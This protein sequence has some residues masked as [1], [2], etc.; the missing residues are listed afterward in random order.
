M[1]FI[2]YLRMFLLVLGYFCFSQYATATENI[3]HE[4]LIEN[5]RETEKL[6]LDNGLQIYLI[7]DPYAENS[8]AAL[9][10]NAG[11]WQNPPEHLGLAHF[12]EHTLFL[13]TKKYPKESGFRDFIS[14][15]GGIYNAFTEGLFTTYLFEIQ[16][17]V[18]KESLIQFATFFEEPLFNPSGIQREKHAV[19][20]EHAGNIEKETHRREAVIKMVSNPEHPGNRFS[21]GNLETLK[22]A[23]P[24]VL[25]RWYENHYSANLMTLT[26]YSPLAM[27]ELKNLIIPVF[28]SIPN[29][30]LSPPDFAQPLFSP[31]PGAI[32]YIQ[33]LDETQTLDLV[34]EIPQDISFSIEEQPDRII[35]HLLGHEST[36]SLLSLLKKEGLANGLASG[37]YSLDQKRKV[38]VIQIDLTKKGVHQAYRVIERVFQAITTLKTQLIPRYIFDHISMT[39][40]L[41][42]LYP[43]Y[44][45]PFEEVMDIATHL[46]AYHLK[47][48]PETALVPRVYNPEAYR[49]FLQIFTPEHA[50]INI[51]ASSALTGIKHQN[52]EPWYGVEYSVQEVPRK[53]FE[54]WK[55]CQ[56]LSNLLIPKKNPWQITKLS[57]EKD[58][59]SSSFPRPQLISQDDRGTLYHSSETLYPCPEV[60]LKLQIHSPLINPSDPR[61]IALSEL[62][63]RMFLDHINEDIYEAKMAGLELNLTQSEGA[64][65][66]KVYGYHEK[67]GLLAK[68]IIEKFNT[69]QPSLEEFHKA[70]EAQSRIYKNFTNAGPLKHGFD[71]LRQILYSFYAPEKAK[72]QALTQVDFSSLR[73]FHRQLLTKTYV[74]GLAYGN[75]SSKESLEIWESIQTTLSKHPLALDERKVQNVIRLPEEPFYIEMK[76]KNRGNAVILAIEN[77]D[78]NYTDLVVSRILSQTLG[79]AFFSE[80]RTQQKTGYYVSQTSQNIY[81]HLFSFFIIES[82]SHDVHDILFRIEMMIETYLQNMEDITL[83]KDQFQRVKEALTAELQHPPKNLR[84]VGSILFELAFKQHADFLWYENQLKALDDLSYEKFFEVAHELLGKENRRRIAILVKGNLADATPW[85]YS[86]AKNTAMIKEKGEFHQKRLTENS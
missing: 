13:G 32:V 17:E 67:A 59:V 19:A 80:L 49:E 18:F 68:T 31:K 84:E 46:H 9:S 70:Y 23:T 6:V 36:G 7:S 65:A 14:E 39:C 22:D 83:T 52:I 48:Y 29:R 62:L 1:Y 47:N 38:F 37:T 57:F 44:Q 50:L 28:E 78:Y 55:H 34:W 66:L 24:E 53:V 58:K 74:Q 56:I 85:K 12:L 3:T 5:R 35:S 61:S 15:H 25:R 79:K 41:D 64:L 45:S 76:T 73:E 26:V 21:T 40:E 33:P 71:A 75:I 51:I 63:I 82:H 20:H 43:K 81:D 10:V 77:P 30:N 4:I 86:K 8:A 42:L 72:L 11:S 2:V 69:Y 16:T 60:Y 27:E 54:E